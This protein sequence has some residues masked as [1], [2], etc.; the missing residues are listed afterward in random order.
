MKIQLIYINDWWLNVRYINII[1]HMEHFIGE[2]ALFLSYAYKMIAFI[3]FL[4][5]VYDTDVKVYFTLVLV[6]LLS[7]NVWLHKKQQQNYC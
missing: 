4:N 1:F 5:P 3:T 2:S 6:F 7:L